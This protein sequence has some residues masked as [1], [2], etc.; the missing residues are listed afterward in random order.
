[1]FYCNKCGK[2]KDWPTNTFLTS[3]GACEICGKKARC[4]DISSKQLPIYLKKAK[5]K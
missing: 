3:I 1:M 2:E 4:N 5:R